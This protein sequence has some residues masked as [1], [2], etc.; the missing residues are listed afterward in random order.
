[1][2]TITVKLGDIILD[3]MTG[4]ELI[5]YGFWGGVEPVA[6][7]VQ[8]KLSGYEILWEKTG[9]YDIKE[10]QLLQQKFMKIDLEKFLNERHHHM[11]PEELMREK[12][13]Y[14]EQ[15]LAHG[16]S[17]DAKTKQPLKEESV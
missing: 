4:K 7:G 9:Q 11:S 13:K 14:R 3:K 17:F 6:N 8:Y 15:F 5:V 16:I 12:I 10:A 1:M 2:N